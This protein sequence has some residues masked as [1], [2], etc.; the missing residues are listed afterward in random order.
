[1]TTR[2]KVNESS[3]SLRRDVKRLGII[4]GEVLVHHGGQEL[5][6]KVETI[7]KLAKELR[8]NYNDGTYQELKKKWKT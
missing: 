6:Q 3:S 2:L 7:R 1:M 8:N 5:L 4:L